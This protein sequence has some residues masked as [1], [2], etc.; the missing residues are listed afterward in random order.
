MAYIYHLLSEPNDFIFIFIPF[1]KM[2]MLKESTFVL[3]T[4]RS[5]EKPFNSHEEFPEQKPQNDIIQKNN[6]LIH[7]NKHFMPSLAH[8]ALLQLE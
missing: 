7:V 5:Q 3:L 1:K 6:P 2:S 8:V 4:F